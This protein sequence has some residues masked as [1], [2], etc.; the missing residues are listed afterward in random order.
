MSSDELISVVIPVYNAEST[1]EQALQSVIDQTYSNIQIIVVNDGSEDAT[2]SI[3]KRMTYDIHYIKQANAGAAEA[4]NNGVNS[5]KGNYIA[6]LDADDVWH[7]QK[8][9]LQMRAFILHPEI[10]F[11]STLG[12]VSDRDNYMQHCNQ[13]FGEAEILVINDFNTIFRNPYFGTPTIMMRKSVFLEVGGLDTSFKTGED[14]DL[15]LR[16]SYGGSVAI[17][18]AK[19]TV[20]IGMDGSLTDRESTNTFSDNLRVIEKFCQMHAVFAKN[21]I[22]LVKEMQSFIYTQWGSAILSNGDR[23]EARKYL[24]KAIKHK[25]M[26]R[27]LFL[28]IKTFKK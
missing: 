21:N 22:G 6:F 11:C 25:V 14:I 7:K 23:H 2:E 17:V 5:A 12:S 13:E 16:T 3:V 10:A 4:R 18:Q 24:L 9:E 20:V 26:L 1:I 15:W 8:L 28:F 27:S 19:L